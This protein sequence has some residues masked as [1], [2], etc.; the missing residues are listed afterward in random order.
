MAL[1]PIALS[2]SGDSGRC[3]T[4]LTNAIP[5]ASDL[6]PPDGVLCSSGVPEYSKN[7]LV[8]VAYLKGWCAAD[9]TL[10]VRRIR[11]DGAQTATPRSVAY[12]KAWWSSDQALN[13]AAEQACG[14]LEGLAPPLLRARTNWPYEGNERAVLAEFI[15]LH[16]LRTRAWRRWYEKARETSLN[17]RTKDWRH[18]N[19]HLAEFL[20]TARSDQETIASFERML[21]SIAGLLGSMHW[22][23]IAFDGPILATSDQPVAPMPL[24]TP[25]GMAPFEAMPASGWL[26]T[27]EARFPISPATGLLMS[28]ATG[29]EPMLRGEWS[30]AINFNQ[31]VIRQ[32]RHEYYTHP[33]GLA[34]GPSGPFCTSLATQLVPGYSE[35]SA[36]ASPRRQ[37]VWQELERLLDRDPSDRGVV[38]I[39]RPRG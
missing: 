24:P 2:R 12:E 27:L 36:Q 11:K 29:P 26:E 30:H 38:P 8:T 37:R 16:I 17:D 19:E 9:G 20:D 32:A 25:S 14:K 13:I 35:D 15:A 22:T 23:L 5:P 18:G 4:W 31:P 28:W 33:D 6:S 7:H 39:V 3:R 21:G 10:R 34:L 1:P